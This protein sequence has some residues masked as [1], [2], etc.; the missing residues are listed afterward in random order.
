ME[1]DQIPGL[2]VSKKA[3]KEK[4]WL[5]FLEA[6]YKDIKKAGM[7]DNVAQ[8][9]LRGFFYWTLGLNLTNFVMTNIL[10]C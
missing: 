8:S 7:T 3:A 10:F 6:K 5:I 4:L 1:R 9:C 2:K